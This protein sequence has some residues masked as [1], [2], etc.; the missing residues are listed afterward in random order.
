MITI[1]ENNSPALRYIGPFIN[2]GPDI[3]FVTSKDSQK[4][5]HIGNNP[6]VTLYFQDS[7]QTDETFKSVSITGIASG[8]PGG[9]DY[10][11]AVESFI[12]KAPRI[13]GWIKGERVTLYK[14]KALKVQFTDFT[15]S[16]S[17]GEEIL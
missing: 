14:I 17:T 13:E 10:D 15:E 11:D 9:K 3:I 7:K 4:V 6:A 5:K 8:I 12:R 16:H 2:S 1:D